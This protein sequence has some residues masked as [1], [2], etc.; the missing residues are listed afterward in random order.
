M[1]VRYTCDMPCNTL[2]QRM[3][4]IWSSNLSLFGEMRVEEVLIKEASEIEREVEAFFSELE[5]RTPISVREFC[6]LLP[7]DWFITSG[8]GHLNGLAVSR[9]DKI[10]HF[11]LDLDV[12]LDEEEK[13]IKRIKLKRVELEEVYDTADQHVYVCTKKR[14]R[15]VV[16][17]FPYIYYNYLGLYEEGNICTPYTEWDVD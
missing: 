1:G 2:T 11:Y 6:Y 17:L 16:E 3:I 5:N 4:G 7:E 14:C 9:G 12:E 13:V 15:E 8:P 10:Y